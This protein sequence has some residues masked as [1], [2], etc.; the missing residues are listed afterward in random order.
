M[1]LFGFLKKLR[2]REKEESKKTPAATQK[3]EVAE[4]SKKS[5]SIQIEHFVLESPHVTERARFL[6]EG[7]Q[8]TFRVQE[9]ATK[10][11]IRNSVER[12]YGV[13]VEDVKVMTIPK[14]PRRRALTRGMKK[15]YKKAVVA[16]RKGEAIDIF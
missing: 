12:M 9:S 7:G 10:R 13:H 1:A 16:L 11:E 2:K 6:S 5:A 8:Y 3:V 14:K 4:P 15:G